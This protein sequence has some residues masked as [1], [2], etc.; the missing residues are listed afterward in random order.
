MREVELKSVVDDVGH[1]RSLIERAGARLVFE[2][3]LVDVRYDQGHG[4]LVAQDQVLR[5]R[6]YERA[7]HNEASIEWKSPTRYEAGYKVRDELSTSVGDPAML[8]EILRRLGFVPIREIEREIA[9]YEIHGATVR[10]E[11]Y[12]RMDPLVEIEGTP[13]GIEKAIQA[14]GLPREGF[15]SERLPDFAA[16]FEQRTGERAALSTGE[17]A[18]NYEYRSDDA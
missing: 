17:L 16:K 7:V 5:I 15:T 9:Q 18:G 4:D 11:R 13:D 1:R 6:V 10:F 14:T 12:P 8:S 2:G 3:R